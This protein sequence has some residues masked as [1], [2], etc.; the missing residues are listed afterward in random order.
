MFEG[1]IR[2]PMI[3][4]WKG[5][6]KPN[7]KTDYVS[8]FWDVWPTLADLINAKPKEETEGISFLPTLLATGKQSNHDHLYWEFYELGGRQAI[9]QG[10]WKL[11]KNDVNKG[12]TYFLFNLNE[13]P[14]ETKNLADQNPD[15]LTRLKLL[16]ESARTESEIF[17][18]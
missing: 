10:N 18:F 11:V 16:M 14:S 4:K 9:R 2:V 3:V 6:I 8:V 1:G 13:D 7:S 15:E 17:N 12:G 5:K